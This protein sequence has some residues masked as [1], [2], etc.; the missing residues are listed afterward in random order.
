MTEVEGVTNLTYP[1]LREALEAGWFPASWT[2]GLLREGYELG[3]GEMREEYWELVIK[4]VGPEGTRVRLRSLPIRI[5]GEGLRKDLGGTEYQAFFPQSALA[6]FL[7]PTLA[8][9]LRPEV[10]RCLRHL[11]RPLRF[12]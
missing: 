7:K 8:S 5:A 6:P 4:E 10:Q 11:R 1:S 2:F 3:F 9:A 12:R